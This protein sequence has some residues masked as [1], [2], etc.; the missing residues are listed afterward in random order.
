LY[1]LVNPPSNVGRI[2]FSC[3]ADKFIWTVRS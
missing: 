2:L 1:G 3:S